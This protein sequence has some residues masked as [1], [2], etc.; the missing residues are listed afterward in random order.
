M[1]EEPRLYA[2]PADEPPL[3]LD[4][5]VDRAGRRIASALVA[6]GALIALALYWQ[7]AP[8]RYQMVASGSQILRIDTRRGTIIGCEGGKC[9]TVLKRGDHLAP[10]LAIDV[11]PKA[12]P[13]PTPAAT[14]PAP[15]APPAR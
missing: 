1:T 14:P 15:T 6:A 7:P 2:E 4:E 5:I 13:A 3:A 11:S 8:P 9:V 10:R 12:A